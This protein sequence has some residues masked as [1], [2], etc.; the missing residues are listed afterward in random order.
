M[1]GYNCP[2]APGTGNVCVWPKHLATSKCSPN[3]TVVSLYTVDLCKYVFDLG[4][5]ILMLKTS[6]EV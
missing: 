6:I 5:Q 2:A 4:L 1:W 3:F